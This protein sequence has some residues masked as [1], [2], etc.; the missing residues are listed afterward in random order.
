MDIPTAARKVAALNKKFEAEWSGLLAAPDSSPQALK[1]HATALLGAYGVTPGT[2]AAAASLEAAHFL[3]ALQDKAH[4]HAITQGL[5]DSEYHELA[6][7]DFLPPVELAAL[8]LLHGHS[9][10]PSL[11][12]ALELHLRIHKKRDDL[13][14]TT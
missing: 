13:K 9:L 12:E 8:K 6:P 10:P 3:D 2:A 11:S 14:F 5:D 1:V 7:A 4:A